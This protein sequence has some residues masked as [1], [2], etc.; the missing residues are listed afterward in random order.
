M[1]KSKNIL[2]AVTGSIAIYKALELIRLF[3]KAE[4]NV[5]VV[6][7]EDAKRFITPLCFEALCG[8]K[9]LDKDTE[10]WANDN[11][12]IAIGKWA[13]ILVLAPATANTINKLSNGLADNLLTQIVLAYDGIKILAPAANTK[14]LENPIS[15][16][17]LKMLKL[18]KY[19]IIK[20]ISKDLLCKDF[21]I[22]ALA[23]V[24][25]IFYASARALLAQ[26][27]WENRNVVLSGG[28]SIEKID[29]VRYISNFSSGKMANSLALALY[30]KGANVCLIST[31]NMD[32]LPSAIH[33]IQVQSADEM[34]QFLQ[35]SLRVAK[36]G[37]LSEMNII[38]DKAKELIQKKPFLFMLAAISDYKPKF[39]QQGK[40]K[41]EVLGDTWKLELKQN[42]DILA[43]LS[44]SKTNANANLKNDIFS[45]GFKAELDEKNAKASAK[46]MLENKELDGVCLNIIS[47]KNPF[48][49]EKNEIEF[50]SKRSEKRNEKTNEKTSEK[51]SEKTKKTESKLSG[52][53]FA[54]SMD[55]LDLLKNE[56][57]NA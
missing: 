4:A 27:F 11:N 14:M 3:T 31:K 30:L 25:D 8:N 12:H 54:V 36:K 17:S 49:G 38:D 53:K 57:T 24:E 9:V 18:C 40:I 20:S 42:E 52:D 26:D 56:F 13:D 50:F 10:S 7:S 23:K 15:Q 37:V 2:I 16:A 46:A 51:T 43:S 32:T 47:H 34:K 28:G 33:K 35:D 21:G 44:N 6:M 1:L 29:D 19:E 48:G 55:L 22:G 45:I 39:A 5:R 41:K